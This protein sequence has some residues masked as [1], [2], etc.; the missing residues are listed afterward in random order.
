MLTRTATRY[1]VP[2]LTFALLAASTAAVWRRQVEH[3]QALL[4]AH[5]EDVCLEVARRL[6]VYVT[7]RLKVA[8]VFAKRWATHSGR[9]F[10]RQRFEEFAAV[11]VDELPGYHAV[12]LLPPGGGEG[13]VVPAGHA[14]LPPHLLPAASAAALRL[15]ASA[16]SG[17]AKSSYRAWASGAGPRRCPRSRILTTRI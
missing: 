9:D 11:L 13:W 4:A 15:A 2:V 12:G 8:A 6:E 14:L 10:S 3:D 1:L 17:G 5:T 7:S 16:S